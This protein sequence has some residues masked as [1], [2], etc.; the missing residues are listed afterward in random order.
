MTHSEIR[1]NLADFISFL[2]PGTFPNIHPDACHL[3]IELG[4]TLDVLSGCFRKPKMLLRF[5]SANVFKNNNTY[6]NFTNIDRT[7]KKDQ[8][9]WF[10]KGILK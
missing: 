7:M 10:R 6:K 1:V 2:L 9:L 4:L 8:D 3:V 5:L